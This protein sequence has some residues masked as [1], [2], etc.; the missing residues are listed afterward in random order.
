VSPGSPIEDK[1]LNSE[2]A[3]T[4][5]EKILILLN[6]E[7]QQQPHPANNWLQN[8]VLSNHY[9]VRKNHQ[10]DFHRL[11]R[12]L[13]NNAIGLVMGGGGARGFA[14][15]G[16]WLALKKAGIPIDMFGGTSMGASMAA[17]CA[18]DWDRES[19]VN[20]HSH[21]VTEAP[22]KQ[23]TLP[24]ISLINSKKLDFLFGEC[25]GELCIEDLWVKYFCVS[26]NLS[27]SEI[28]IHREGTLWQAL[29]ASSAIPGILTPHIHQQGLLVDGGL[30]NNLPGDIMR[31]HCRYVIVSDVSTNEDF[32]WPEK[33]FPSPL[34]VLLHRY[35]PFRKP[36]E[37]PGI[38]DIMMRSV[39][40]SS[41][42]KAKQ[43]KAEADLYL[44]PP[45]GEFDMMDF[46]NLERL[47]DIGIIHT[48]SVLAEN[49]ILQKLAS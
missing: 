10:Q 47:I 26:A 28:M 12:F 20:F 27:R 24:L 4:I 21:T 5:A 25:Y 40:L 38:I 32:T 35:S 13:T 3:A 18:I 41:T 33:T 23:F 34:K 45:V 16:V 9:H 2:Q 39:L 15:F 36:L 1:L 6:D 46:T 22:F 30:M 42:Q 48:E 37:V 11:A 7:N 8:R 14:H 49:D 43:I 31:Q 17:V 44:N 29:R 19:L